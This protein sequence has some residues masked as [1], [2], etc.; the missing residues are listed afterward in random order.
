M[1]IVVMEEMRCCGVVVRQLRIG[2]DG[3]DLSADY[4]GPPW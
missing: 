1:L 2:L 3:D 4:L